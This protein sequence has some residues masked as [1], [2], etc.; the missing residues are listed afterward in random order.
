MV[1]LIRDE[2]I[3]P[4]TWPSCLYYL[5]LFLN[6]FAD[7]LIESDDPDPYFIWLK[8]KKIIGLIAD[9][10]SVGSEDGLRIDTKIRVQPTIIADRIDPM[11]CQ[12]L[13]ERVYIHRPIEPKF[14][15]NSAAHL[16]N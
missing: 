2:L 1:V 14:H 16:I 7:V 8:R 15:L 12:D 3:G 10:V 13:V 5:V 6:E 9:I 11:N 4:P